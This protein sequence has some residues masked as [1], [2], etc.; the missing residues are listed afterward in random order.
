MELVARCAVFGIAAAAR[1]PMER[2]Q[3]TTLDTV[4]QRSN[5]RTRFGLP[6]LRTSQ[7]CGSLPC[8]FVLVVRVA[9]APMPSCAVRGEQLDDLS[10]EEKTLYRAGV[11]RCNYLTSDRPDIAFSVKELCRSMSSPTA[12]DML[13]LKRMCRYLK[14]KGRLV[15]L[16]P[17]A[18][19][20]RRG[21][22][23]AEDLHRQ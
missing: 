23:G 3:R 7:A 6:P 15:Q 8:G 10:P 2:P 5:G 22:M 20:G 11:A 12:A 4:K 17:T 14:G 13:A 16:I 21:E 9:H 18:P 19:M 1:R